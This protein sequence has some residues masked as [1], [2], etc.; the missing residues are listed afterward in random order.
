I[1]QITCLQ[2]NL[3]KILNIVE[4]IIGRNLTLPILNNILLIVEKN[5]LKIS[6][7][8]LEIGINCWLNGKIEKEGSITVPAK[9]ISAFINNLPNKKITLKSKNNQLEVKCENFKSIINGLNADDFPIIPQITAPPL[10]KIKSGV[11][12]NNFAQVVEMVSFSELKPEITGIYTEFD[13]NLIK[14][15]ATN[16]FRLAEKV[17]ETNN[18]ISKQSIIIPQK[19][20][21]ELIR[22][23]GEED[24]DV[25]IVLSNNQILFNLGNIQI[26]SKLIDGQYPDYQQI[27]PDKF[28]TQIVINKADLINNIKIASLFSENNNNIN[29]LIKP[30]QSI[31]EISAKSGDI[32][33]NKSQ[34]EAKIEGK[35][36]NII[37]NS[38]YFLDGLNNIFSDKVIIGLNGDTKPVTVR[39][40]KDI[41]YTYI[42][43]PIKI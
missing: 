19:T 1:M 25:D 6:S 31:V 36:L 33:E 41:S 18:K 16:S 9:L 30:T 22:I 24:T 27:I 26:I 11:L 21:Q 3:K 20:I 14:L 13:N 32:G 28:Q 40:F 29:F 5:K 43:M 42:V 10:I 38:R 12:K 15:A 8:N 17:I 34:L 39:P 37:L 2:E 4:R 23:L 7:T 35:G